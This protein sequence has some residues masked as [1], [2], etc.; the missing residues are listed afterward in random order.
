MD[1]STLKIGS[2][3]K[4]VCRKRPLSKRE[5]SG[6]HQDVVS[7]EETVVTV[8]EPKTKVDLTRYTEEHVFNFDDAFDEYSTN[9][10]LYDRAVKPLISGLFENL[11][12]TCFAYGQTGSGKTFTTLGPSGD[13]AH[14]AL[15]DPGHVDAG[16][17]L[18]A[19]QDIFDRLGTAGSSGQSGTVRV[20]FYEIYCGKL[21][22]LLNERSLLC[23]RENGRKEVVIV[24]LRELPVASVSEMMNMVYQGLAAR[25]TGQTAANLDS[26]R[27]H[28]ILQIALG[29][30]GKLSFIDLAGSER[31]ADTMDQDRQTRI[32]GAEINKSLLAL[33]E[34]IRAMDLQLD[35]TPFRGSKLTQVLRDSFVGGGQVVMIANLSPSSACVEHSL[36]TLRYAYR[37]KELPRPAPFASRRGSLAPVEEEAEEDESDS[38]A[39]EGRARLWTPEDDDDEF[40]PRP[41]AAPITAVAVATAKGRRGKRGHEELIGRILNEEELLVSEHRRQVDKHVELLQMEMGE[42]EMIERPGSDVEQYVA[43]LEE[44]LKKKTEMVERLRSRVAQFRGLLREEARMCTTQRVARD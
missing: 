18:K 16:I 24:G 17:F 3:I 20:S 38:A 21:Y 34:C 27:S 5:T 12:G 30:S 28:A 2:R 37:V 8:R 22:D 35:H 41:P 4:V 32:D 11:R 33:K 15:A 26:S 14:P 13:S 25:T 40:D 43:F 19:S 42:L 29:V 7:V 36:N 9:Q 10:D 23:A 31:G 6:R 44:N 1:S 39:P